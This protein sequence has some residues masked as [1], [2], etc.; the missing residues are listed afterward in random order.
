MIA[1]LANHLAYP[2]L[3]AAPNMAAA[4]G[5]TPLADA[6][7]ALTASAGVMRQVNGGLTSVLIGRLTA[8]KTP[9]TARLPMFHY[10]GWLILHVTFQLLTVYT[11]PTTPAEV[12]LP[13]FDLDLNQTTPPSIY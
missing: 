1:I 3:M 2:P 7:E 6:F 5:G 10:L 4:S 9:V 11:R 8:R 13:N 12:A